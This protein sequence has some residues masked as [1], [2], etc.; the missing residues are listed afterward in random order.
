VPVVLRSITVQNT[1]GFIE[2]QTQYCST[3]RQYG[4]V[5]LRGRDVDSFIIVA[6]RIVRASMKK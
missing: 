2:K 6:T 4:I 5:P 1:A 3:V